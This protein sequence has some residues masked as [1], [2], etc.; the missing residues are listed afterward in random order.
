M[1]KLI[2]VL[3]SFMLIFT[4]VVSAAEEKEAGGKNPDPYTEES[5]KESE[6]ADQSFMI[7]VGVGIIY[8]VVISK[9]RVSVIFSPIKS[10]A[11]SLGLQFLD[12]L[13]GVEEIRLSFKNGQSVVLPAAAEIKSYDVGTFIAL[14]LSLN[15]VR[16]VSDLVKI[17]S[18]PDRVAFVHHDGTE[19]EMSFDELN[20]AFSSAFGGIVDLSAQAGEA[21]SVFLNNLRNGVVILMSD[22]SA[23]VKKALAE[24]EQWISKTVSSAGQSAAELKDSA[25]AA[26]ENAREKAGE[27]MENAADSLK[28][29]WNSLRKRFTPEK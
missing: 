15:A 1:K 19:Q 13:A 16:A 10:K 14:N 28:T 6:E 17:K 20:Q 3:L 23:S 25:E 8:S 24:A 22:S 29:L 12:S 2:A 26:W 9:D 7:P 18:D 27:W 5:G 21:V 11:A 4:A